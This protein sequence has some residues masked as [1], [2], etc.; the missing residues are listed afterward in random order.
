M[1]KREEK[2]E[3]KRETERIRGRKKSDEREKEMVLGYFTRAVVWDWV[4]S[5]MRVGWYGQVPNAT[6]SKLAYVK[7]G[8]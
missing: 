5:C 7:L 3:E 1:S 2:R 6:R 8:A 4:W